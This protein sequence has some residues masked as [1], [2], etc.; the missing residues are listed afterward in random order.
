MKR[1]LIETLSN[2]Q[3]EDFGYDKR[4][5]EDVEDDEDRRKRAL[6]KKKST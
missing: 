4:F 6:K 3:L 5:V 2:D 1:D